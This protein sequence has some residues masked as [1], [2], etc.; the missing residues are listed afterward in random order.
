MQE[1]KKNKLNKSLTGD[2]GQ[3]ALQNWYD[4]MNVRK[5]I[6]KHIASIFIF[7]FQKFK[8]I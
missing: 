5:N 4:N 6:Q 8:F 1:K 7:H 3:N 2:F